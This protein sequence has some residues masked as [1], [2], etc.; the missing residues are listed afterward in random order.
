[1]MKKLVLYA[2][3][4]LLS[5]Y[6]YAQW[7]SGG[8]TQGIFTGNKQIRWNFG[9]NGFVVGYTKAQID[10]AIT[11]GGGGAVS[12]VV[13][14]NNRITVSP[15]TGNAVVN[16][17]PTFE[18]LLGKVASPLSQFATTTSA[19]IRGVLSDETGTGVAVFNTNPVFTAPDIGD[20]V[21]GSVNFTSLNGANATYF[22]PTSSIQ[23]QLNGK[24]ASLG[25]T[26]ENTANKVT[27]LSGANNTTYPTS[28]AVSDAI[29]AAG[30]GTVLN[31][32]SSTSDISVA[33]PTTTPTLTLGFVNGITKSYYD[34]TSSIQT[35]LNARELLSNKTATQSSST[36]TYPNWLG[37]TNY[38]SGGFQPLNSNLT[39]FSALASS[40]G[41]LTNT[42]GVYSWATPTT[43]TVTNVSSANADINVASGTT[44]PVLTLNTGMGANQIAKRDGSGDLGVF[45]GKLMRFYRGDNLDYAHIRSSIGKANLIL[46]DTLILDNGSLFPV[47]DNLTN[48]GSSSFRFKDIYFS[49]VAHGIGSGLTNIP[50]SSL[51]NSSVTINGNNVALGSSTTVTANTS[52]S[53]TI[54]NNLQLSSGTT[55]DGS[56]AKTLSI[57]NAEA[58]GSTRGAAS[59]T[60]SDFN[61]SSGNISIDYT[62]GQSA[63]GS[64]KGFL[65]SSDWTSF[66]TKESVL[67][68]MTP[69]IR[70]GNTITPL[71]GT[72]TNTFAEG[73]DSRIINGQTAYTNRI[74]SLTNTGSSG[75][76]SL[77]SNVLNI[78]TYT[79]AGLGGQTALN[80]TGFVKQVGTTT[81]Y[82][83]STYLSLPAGASQALTDALYQKGNSAS[84]LF[85]N[86]TPFVATN[87][88]YS[89]LSNSLG[90]LTF[91]L[92]G[93][94]GG[95]NFPGALPYAITF[96]TEKN[97][98]IHFGT[99][100]LIRLTVNGSGFF[101]LHAYG[102]GILQT[103][104]SGNVTTG[105]TLP[106]GTTATTQGAADNSTKVA[107]TAYV[108][109]I[110]RIVVST[111]STSLTVPN[112]IDGAVE[113]DLILTGSSL[114]TITLPADV[115]EGARIS[116]RGVG[117][118]GWIIAQGAGNVIK[119]N[120][121]STTPGTGGYVQ[122]TS[123]YNCITIEC[124]TGGFSNT[125]PYITTSVQGGPSFN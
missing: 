43:G 46:N 22:D 14:T 8:T 75:A 104:A 92:E 44:T 15:T 40:N 16:I 31:V 24:Q 63:S 6:S 89:Y 87:P 45:N 81:S 70:I 1:M 42:G 85:Q 58:D 88:L 72:S 30:G 69:I 67:T 108:D 28:K 26:P 114:Q 18:A 5:T 38:V 98:S 112:L 91:G 64:T 116:I 125:S 57:Q 29:S 54:G 39:A 124:T 34:V 82:D 52:N 51:N 76:A 105:L 79:L 106:N 107:T 83:N 25:F 73:N 117:T 11:A 32:S 35:Q 94:A 7:T 36:S 68:F 56:S 90:S 96:G 65:N 66:N 109:A 77:I 9:A 49:G 80:G 47:V 10:S 60:A 19:Q 111:S 3:L 13:G 118:G 55:F 86:V 120:G 48:L 99:N 74:S 20:A 62:N 59:F 2:F 110:K 4:T 102:A 61:A 100:N 71:F 101:R 27:T 78:P 50:N 84:G 41:V 33:N 53:L 17:S 12:S 115:T 123:Q 21:G 121:G 23:T 97:Q 93:S 37:V 103:D 95:Y 113:Y 122:S 119:T